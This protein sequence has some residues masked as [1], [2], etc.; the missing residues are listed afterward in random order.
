M[1][2]ATD[3][4]DLFV[5]VHGEGPPLVVM[6][7]GLGLDHTYL[8]PWLDRLGEVVTLVYYDHRGHGRSPAP[9]DWDAVTHATWVADADA[10]RECLGYKQWFVF[11]HSYGGF[12]ALEYA[13]AY[14]D[15]IAGVVLCCT[16]AAFD[17]GEAAF[18]RAER[19]ATPE[20]LAVLA[21]AFSA[22][23]PNDGAMREGFSA[24]L[25]VYLCDPDPS[26]CE[27]LK[28]GV[29]FSADG[30]NRAFFGCL[31]DYDV[32]GRLSEIDA[33]VLV[34]S[35]RHDWLFAP[36]DGGDV[37]AAG[38]PHTEHVVFEHSGHYP[39]VEEPEP[40]VHAVTTWL[41]SHERAFPSA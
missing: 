33:P 36:E 4:V 9:D 39:F 40:F 13:L 23:L 26:T 3:S 41:E 38:L 6:H 7:G 22:P 28:A 24:V 17:H 8:R 2:H 11:G 20:Q 16:S 10:L 34:L 5:S 30:F 14:P 12:L 18:A 1:P 31:S 37:L 35:G 32:R 29:R 15:R 25:P 27:A 21:G 19:R